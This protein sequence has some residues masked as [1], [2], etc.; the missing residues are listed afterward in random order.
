[1]GLF[2]DQES[3][4]RFVSLSISREYLNNLIVC[5][6]WTRLWIYRWRTSY[7][8]SWNWRLSVWYFPA[9]PR[10]WWDVFFGRKTSRQC[11]IPFRARNGGR[12]TC[13]ETVNILYQL[14]FLLSSLINS[15]S[16]QTATLISSQE[17][18]LS[19]YRRRISSTA[20]VEAFYFKSVPSRRYESLKRYES[21]S[22]AAPG[23]R[24]SNFDSFQKTAILGL[25]AGG[26]M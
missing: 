9:S 18:S 14:F 6:G 19:D 23:W 24:H 7:W 22:R 2:P 8:E 16:A 20:A 3:F 4:D 12:S 26:K 11:F 21:L 25:A 1:M 15:I 17:W 5:C 10:S 13:V